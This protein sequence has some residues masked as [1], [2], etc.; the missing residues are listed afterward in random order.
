MEDFQH[1]RDNK[2]KEL[3]AI[4]DHKER[5]ERVAPLKN[6]YSN[7]KH[8]YEKSKTARVLGR[9][10]EFTKEN[11]SPEV[12][13]TIE[14][15]KQDI[16]EYGTAHTSLLNAGSLNGAQFDSILKNGVL[17][18]ARDGNRGRDLD[19][20]EWTKDLKGGRK[21]TVSFNIMGRSF[22]NDDIDRVLPESIDFDTSINA[23][24]FLEKLQERKKRTRSFS[25]YPGEII[26]FDISDL[27]EEEPRYI[28]SI[29]DG[30]NPNDTMESFPPRT[31]GIRGPER[32]TVKTPD[33]KGNLC[34]TT[35]Y[36]FSMASR[37]APR[38]FKGIIVSRGNEKELMKIVSIMLEA[39]KDKPELL[40]PIYDERGNLI[41][42]RR[43][44]YEEFVGQSDLNGEGLNH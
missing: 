39:Y 13:E 18:V 43:I 3:K 24:E 34:T 27:K 11:L 44:P 26:I 14:K 28:N 42:P 36:G 33:K 4:P 7:E 38:R 9:V 32:Y 37:V 29:G 16:F 2:A 15:K 41:W 40:I 17:G 23:P 20:G 31:Y 10:E 6:Y 5:R 30:T 21:V 8:I 22:E 19:P 12:I 35:E 25:R 1:W